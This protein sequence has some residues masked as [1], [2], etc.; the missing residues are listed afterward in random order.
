MSLFKSVPGFKSKKK[1]SDLPFSLFE[2]GEFSRSPRWANEA[3][4]RSLCK[5]AYLGDSTALCRM[6][7]RYKIYVDTQDFGL[8]PHLLL[9]GYWEMWLTEVIAQQVKPGM[10]VADVGANIG[11]YTLLMAELVGATGKVHAFE[12]N[13]LMAQKISQSVS[14]NGFLNNVAIHNIALAEHDGEQMV[15][16]VPPHEPKNAYLIPYD[17]GA[18]EQGTIVHTH[19]LDSPAWSDIEFA[20][21]DVEGAE[22]L[23]WAGAKGL[24]DSGKLK[25][26]VLEFTGG[27]YADPGRF[28]EALLVP[29]FSLS[30]VDMREGIQ[31]LTREDVLAHD[32]NED[33]LLYLQR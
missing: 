18:L 33:L 30:H 20:K 26:V 17:G 32:P 25:T 2:I 29:G 9:D 28:L 1:P 10:I 21:I 24:L 12:P 5:V 16:I 15:F 13:P 23:I 8:A 31:P 22:Q 4:I 7:G 6:L 27:R 3:A 11:Y 14:I 19:R